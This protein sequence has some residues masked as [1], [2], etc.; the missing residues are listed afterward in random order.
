MLSW[1]ERLVCY[2]VAETEGDDKLSTE[3]T[4]IG[5]VSCPSHLPQET[6]QPAKVGCTVCCLE[7]LHQ[8]DGEA[9]CTVPVVLTVLPL[10]S[11]SPIFKRGANALGATLVERENGG[12]AV[13]H[14]L[15][16]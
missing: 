11:D 10:S 7:W 4:T 6:F 15:E 12:G 1:P 2:T 3:G 5:Y 9:A 16:R 13:V 8:Q 14:L